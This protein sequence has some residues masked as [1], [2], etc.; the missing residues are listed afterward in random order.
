MDPPAGD[1]DPSPAEAEAPSDVELLHLTVVQAAEDLTAEFQDPGPANPDDP[2]IT[3]E[4]LQSAK[5]I[6]EAIHTEDE[7]V[8]TADESLPDDTTGDTDSPDSSRGAKTWPRPRTITRETDGIGILN[9]EDHFGDKL[10]KFTET[11]TIE[12]MQR[13][14]I[15]PS[16]LLKP[17]ETDMNEYPNF[18]D[19][20]EKIE[21]LLVKHR[22][23]LIDQVIDEREVILH[24]RKSKVTA[25]AQAGEVSYAEQQA[26]AIERIE[27]AQK[28]E[29]EQMIVAELIREQTVRDQIALREKLEARQLEL[30]EEVKKRQ[31]A[32]CERRNQKTQVLMARQQERERELASLR[33]Q[34]EE[35]I[36]KNR[37]VIEEMKAKRLKEMAE[38]DVQR[39]KKAEAQR[40]ALDR[41]LEEEKK[42]ILAKQKEQAAREQEMLMRRE[43]RLVELKERNRQ[44]REKQQAQFAIFQQL[45]VKRMEE[46]RKS[47]EVK[48]KTAKVRYDSVIKSR[49]DLTEQVRARTA[50]QVD[51]NRN[52][53]Q[54]I[55]KTREERIRAVVFKDRQDQER[56]DK[57]AAERQ[58]RFARER[59]LEREKQEH[60]QQQ[61][62]ERA[63]AQEKKAVLF[64]KKQEKE[65]K[66][67]EVVL[68]RKADELTK[69]VAIQKVVD[70]LRDEIAD[71]QAKQLHAKRQRQGELATH[72]EARA[73]TYVDQQ[74]VLALKK[75]DAAT[76]LDFKKA[77]TI[78]EFREFMKKGGRL[79]ID[80]LAKK[81]NIDLEYLRR[82]VEELRKAKFV[83]SGQSRPA[84]RTESKADKSASTA[85]GA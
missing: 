20:R 46:R 82:K 5:E 7:A 77:E 76:L 4:M 18:P 9:F 47:M 52:A 78:H 11:S 67:V 31:A 36:E 3:E 66:S 80:A 1:G 39:Q 51:R 16:Q 41:Q 75:R 34:Q 44:V 49:E 69:K 85:E 84:S 60:I 22:Q 56:R 48:E 12:A 64:E 61:N 8:D 14:F 81:F 43:A 24:E 42:V 79:N 6:V 55:E 70:K 30:A 37:R 74:R 25:V 2:G 71:R 59:Q 72:R 21:S 58:E 73:L 13:L 26:A 68:K 15:D 23:M 19:C 45:A 63:A 28:T 40:E 50:T 57:I 53:K 54:V 65:E 32:D 27:K 33:K 10:P 17:T 38:A 83:D 35:Q 29:I 62:Q